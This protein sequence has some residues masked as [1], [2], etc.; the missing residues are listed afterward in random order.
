MQIS[1]A[2]KPQ[3]GPCRSDK[4]RIVAH[5]TEKFTCESCGKK[6]VAQVAAGLGPSGGYHQAT[7][8]RCGCVQ[9]KFMSR[10]MNVFDG[11]VDFKTFQI[12]E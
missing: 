7:C 5:V 8:P 3:I 11:D 9:G 4:I 10:V 1:D 2:T 12:G 6:L